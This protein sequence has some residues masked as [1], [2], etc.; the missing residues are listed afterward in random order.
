MKRILIL[1]VALA[2][3][4]LFRMTRPAAEGARESISPFEGLGA[5]GRPGLGRRLL[6]RLNVFRRWQAAASIRQAYREMCVAA[7]EK[8][9]PRAESE[10]PY[11]YLPA[12]AKAWPEHQ[13]EAT[14]ITEA[15]NRAHYG[16]LPE[17]EEELQEILAAWKRLSTIDTVADQTS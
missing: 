6:D 3:G 16:E 11:E 14:L 10:T 2:L 17:T 15:Y 7:A 4:R 5:P 9:Y 12:L 8:G 1:L 13:S